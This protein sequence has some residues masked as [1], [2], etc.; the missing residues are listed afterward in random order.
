M[1]TV[2]KLFVNYSFIYLFIYPA[3]PP[4]EKNNKE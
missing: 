4:I 1:R 2:S 3:V